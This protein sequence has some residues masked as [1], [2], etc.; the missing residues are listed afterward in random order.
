[1]PAVPVPIAALILWKDSVA[2]PRQ[3]PPLPNR[4]HIDVFPGAYYHTFTSRLEA[5]CILRERVDQ[6]FRLSSLALL[7]AALLCD[8]GRLLSKPAR[9]SWPVSHH[10]VFFPC[11]PVPIMAAT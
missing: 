1:M 5:C 9:T 7:R 8:S 10:Q 4:L 6:T 2:D 11:V 3:H